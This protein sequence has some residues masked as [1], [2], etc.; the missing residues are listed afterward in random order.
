VEIKERIPSC[1]ALHSNLL[2]LSNIILTT[3]TSHLS[4][5]VQYIEEAQIALLYFSEA[6]LPQTAQL[7]IDFVGTF[8]NESGAGFFLSDN[9]FDPSALSPEKKREAFANWSEMK[10]NKGRTANKL[11]LQAGH[12]KM[13]AT[14]VPSF[15]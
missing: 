14:Q 13:Y 2:N 12:G 9:Y 15:F 6:I 7:S 4:A 1:I 10:F 11:S 5:T 3:S 8:N